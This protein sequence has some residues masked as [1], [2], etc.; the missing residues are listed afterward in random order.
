MERIFKQYEH[1]LAIDIKK[2]KYEYKVNDYTVEKYKGELES[3]QK[4]KEHIERVLFEEKIY[5]GFFLIKGGHIKKQFLH[6]IEELNKVLFQCVK[7]KIDLTN[8][9]IEKE[10]EYILSIINKD[11]I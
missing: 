6:K 10:V 8:G 4:A 3:N 2:F 7:K 9:L 1:I 11:P 5:C